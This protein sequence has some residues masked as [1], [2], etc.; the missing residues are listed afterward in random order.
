MV[1]QVNEN[2]GLEGKVQR[3]NKA[4]VDSERSR[5]KFVLWRNKD[6]PNHINLDSSVQYFLSIQKK[7]TL[8]LDNKQQLSL[9]GGYVK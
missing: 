5:D 3:N 6:R 8:D 9:P 1:S 2:L 7:E 4:L